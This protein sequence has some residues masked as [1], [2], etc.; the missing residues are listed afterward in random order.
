MEIRKEKRCWWRSDNRGGAG[1][2]QTTEE[3]RVETNK[4]E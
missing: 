4:M 2:D 3:V 1:G